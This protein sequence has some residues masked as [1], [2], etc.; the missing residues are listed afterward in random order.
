MTHLVQWVCSTGVQALAGHSRIPCESTCNITGVWRFMFSH[1]VRSHHCFTTLML[2]AIQKGVIWSW[3]SNQYPTHGRY[4]LRS[5]KPT[6][7]CMYEEQLGRLKQ[8]VNECRCS[9]F[10]GRFWI[11]D[12]V[13]HALCVQRVQLLLK[14]SDDLIS[15]P[16][17]MR[18]WALKCQL[19]VQTIKVSVF[20][21]AADLWSQACRGQQPLWA[22][23][24]RGW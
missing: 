23:P 9:V 11:C 4:C 16:C 8:E 10:D 13:N 3:D 6:S 7:T 17:F 22:C 12:G 19:N 15:Q 21:N 1:K 14:I 5:Q 24:V 18:E 2:A 20:M